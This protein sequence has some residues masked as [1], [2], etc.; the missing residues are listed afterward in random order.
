[1]SLH[2]RTVELVP[3]ERYEDFGDI[4]PAGME[5]EDVELI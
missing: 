4:P 3:L 2:S 1:M 5:L